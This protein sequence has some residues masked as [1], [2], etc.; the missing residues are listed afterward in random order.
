MTLRWFVCDLR[1]GRIVDD[2]DPIS[3]SWS[4]ALNQA[5]TLSAVLNMNDPATAS[6]EIWNI[7]APTRMCLCVAEGD[8]ILAGGPIWVRR[9]GGGRV[10]INAKGMWSYFDHRFI[11]PVLAATT[12]VD[13]F[14]IQ[15]PADVSKTMANPALA[16]RLSGMSLGT[17]AKRLVQQARA[18]T[19]GNVPV[20]FQADESE[21]NAD[22]ERNWVATDFKSVGS[23]LSDLTGVEN[24]PE[25]IF[26]PRFTADRLSVE[27]VLMTGTKAQPQITS[28]TVHQWDYGTEGALIQDVEIVE[29]GSKIAALGWATA[30]PEGGVL[31]SRS[32]NPTSIGFGSA[33]FELV[34]SSHSTVSRQVTLDGYSA[35]AVSFGQ[36]AAEVWSMSID[37]QPEGSPPL[38]PMFAVGDSFDLTIPP[39]DPVAGEGDSSIPGK[40]YRHRITGRGGSLASRFVDLDCAPTKGL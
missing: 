7:T 38:L 29:D 21:E 23:A 16:T 31:V 4:Q 28:E 12:R 9:R 32:Y 30:T 8:T 27:W 19:G 26:Q 15:D 25:I 39:F 10:T 33:L 3:G 24:G 22:N 6:Q 18:W 37:G 17:V 40:V 5:D 13:Q 35:A 11:L 34:D 14:V 1:T 2:L 20:V 36:S